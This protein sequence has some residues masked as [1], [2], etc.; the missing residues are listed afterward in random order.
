MLSIAL[1]RRLVLR[2]EGRKE[3]KMLVVL[4]LVLL[5]L[6]FGGLGFLFHPLFWIGLI[7]ILLIGGGGYYRHSHY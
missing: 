6:L 5:L 2:F 7:L 4:L 1:R 3:I